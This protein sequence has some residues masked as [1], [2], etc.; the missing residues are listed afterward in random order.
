[1]IMTKTYGTSNPDPLFEKLSA[2][3]FEDIGNIES[4]ESFFSMSTQ[5]K[6]PRYFNHYSLSS[7]N[8]NISVFGTIEEIDG[9]L[10]TEKSIKGIKCELIKNGT[11]AR[12]RALNFASSI[13]LT[14][15]SKDDNSD[16]KYKI[17][18]YSDEEYED[19]V[20]G[21]DNLLRRSFSYTTKIINGQAVTVFDTSESTSSLIPR[22]SNKII[23][24]TEDSHNLP[25]FSDRNIVPA[26]DSNNNNLS[27]Q[28]DY[29]VG[30]MFPSHGHDSDNSQGSGPDSAAF[31]GAQD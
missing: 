11:D 26:A 24:Y 20:T 15:L 17:E 21:D 23:F 22:L 3:P 30:S 16:Q 12:D 18:S 13:T 14:E 19:L 1:M 28:N 7:L 29:N 27:T 31:I 10:L 9:T 2:L 8:S 6:Y 25:P 5:V 4:V